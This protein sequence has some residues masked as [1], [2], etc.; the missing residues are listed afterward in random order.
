MSV[1]S[2]FWHFTNKGPG[3]IHVFQVRHNSARSQDVPPREALGRLSPERAETLRSAPL[4][5]VPQ[6]PV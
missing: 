3:S 2:R 1:T 6:L 4:T 5:A